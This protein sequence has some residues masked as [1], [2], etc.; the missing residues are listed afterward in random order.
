MLPPEIQR[1]ILLIGLA[2][3]A[4]LIILAWNDDM[5]AAKK[6]V[7]YSSAPLSSS[8]T[9]HPADTIALTDTVTTDI[10]VTSSTVPAPDENSD[11]PDASF[12]ITPLQSQD[13]QTIMAGDER[14]IT[15]TTAALKVWIDLVGG[16][17]VRVQLPKFPVQLE[18]PDVPYVLL[19]NS[20]ARTYVAQSGLIGPN[21]PDGGSTRPVYRTDREDVVVGPSGPKTVVLTTQHEGVTV[22]KSFTF[23]P[24]DYLIEV[25]YE[26]NNTTREVFKAGM[27]AQL[28]RDSKTPADDDA[29]FLGPRP[30]LGAAITKPDERY[31]KVEFEDVDEEPLRETITGGWVAFLQHYFLSAWVP[32][33][34][35]DNQFY[36]RKNSA[37]TYLFGYTGPLQEVAP[38]RMGHW[39][40]QFYAGP[41]DQNRLEEIAPNLNLTIDYGFLW[42]LAIP[43]F[44]LLDWLH[45][46]VNNWGLAIILLTVIVKTLLYPLAAAG[47]K[48]MANMRRVAPAMKKLQERYSND[49]EKLSRE[50]MALYKKEG[51][52]PLGGCLPMLLPMPIFLA[53]YWVLFE[54][55]ELRQAPFFLWI[56][57]LAVMDPFF[58]LP[59]AMGASMYWMQSLNPQMGDPMQVKMMKMMPIMFTVLFLFF[60]AGLVLYWLVNNVLSIGQQQYVYKQAE[61]AYANKGK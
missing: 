46:L 28:K 23:Q 10:P 48:S 31:F 3:T 9:T 21:G 7:E 4:Y 34:E 43:L 50:M 5:E 55:V 17:I 27:F 6:P 60:P 35:Q 36:A 53:L 25:A 1:V 13:T 24:E 42:W 32:P 29:F 45:G 15:I 22:S 18:Q 40:T 58:V 39:Q 19:D 11:V 8:N 37:G 30:Y 61:K 59:L 44:H 33:Q 12:L 49:K 54:S 47:Y 41:K 16:D 56:E 52:N 38:G 26:V 2:A 20:A 51:A 14:L 57:D